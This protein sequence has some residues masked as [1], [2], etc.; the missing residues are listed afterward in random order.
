MMDIDCQYPSK[1]SKQIATIAHEY[2]S[3]NKAY[4]V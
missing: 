1:R 3:V 4:S 2:H